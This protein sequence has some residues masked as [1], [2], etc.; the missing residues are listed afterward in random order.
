MNFGLM[1]PRMWASLIHFRNT[2]EYS[3]T[4]ADFAKICD[5]VIDNKDDL[6][7]QIRKLII[8]LCVCMGLGKGELKSMIMEELDEARGEIDI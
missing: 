2:A 1:A 3:D 4:F 7:P 5:I 6:N 8:E